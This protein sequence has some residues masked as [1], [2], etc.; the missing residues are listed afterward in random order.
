[1]IYGWRKSRVAFP[2]GWHPAHLEEMISNKENR[3]QVPLGCSMGHA[4]FS[5][6]ASIQA[7]QLWCYVTGWCHP[8]LGCD[9]QW[10]VSFR[11]LRI[12]VCPGSFLLTDVSVPVQQHPVCGDRLPPHA[13]KVYKMQCKWNIKQAAG[14]IQAGLQIHNDSQKQIYQMFQPHKG[15]KRLS[16]CRNCV[17]PPVVLASC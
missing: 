16:Y 17:L 13:D 5:A 14:R 8:T 4:P 1:M 6:R 9:W 11:V 15:A 12:L 10:L 3:R 2:G 7:G